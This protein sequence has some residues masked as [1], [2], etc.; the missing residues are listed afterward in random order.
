MVYVD[1]ESRVSLLQIMGNSLTNEEFKEYYNDKSIELRVT[2]VAHSQ[3]NGQTKFTNRI[4][5]DGLK[6]RVE[7]SGNTWVDDILWAYRTTCKVATKATPFMSAYVAE[8]VVPFEITHGSLRVEVY[9]PKIN[10]EGK[11]LALNLI[12]EVRDEANALNTEHQR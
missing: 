10:E 3:A 12:D 11:R 1:L 7:H 8:A 5:L 9:E 4:I 6:K 2:S